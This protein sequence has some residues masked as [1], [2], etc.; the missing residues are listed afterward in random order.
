LRKNLGFNE[1]SGTVVPQRGDQ[2]IEY[3]VGW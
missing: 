3:S 2:R 1:A